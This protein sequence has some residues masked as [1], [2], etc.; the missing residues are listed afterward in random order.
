[1]SDDIINCPLEENS[2]KSPPLKVAMRHHIRVSNQGNAGVVGIFGGFIWWYCH[3]EYWPAE[4][5]S[6]NVY[7]TAGSNGLWNSTV[8]RVVQSA[9]FLHA[10][11]V[12][13]FNMWFQLVP[14]RL[15]ICR[16]EHENAWGKFGA[17]A[18]R[19]PDDLIFL[20]LPKCKS[21]RPRAIGSRQ[22]SIGIW[23][24]LWFVQFP[25]AKIP[26]GTANNSTFLKVYMG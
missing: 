20:R 6:E 9:R 14:L 18:N 1:M 16:T 8:Q 22:D 19:P 4:R 15:K 21:F 10:C 7:V 2:W 12:P 26:S 13:G 5:D 24:F 25:K 11:L 3:G 17:H 23:R